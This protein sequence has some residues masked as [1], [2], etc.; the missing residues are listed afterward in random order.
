MKISE[1]VEKTYYR[2]LSKQHDPAH[3]GHIEWYTDDEEHAKLYT[4]GE[5]DATIITNDI[6]DDI[7][8]HSFEHGFR[9]EQTEITAED[10]ADRVK[11]GIVSAFKQGWIDKESAIALTDE[12]YDIEFPSVY[13]KV[14]MWWQ[15]WHDFTDILKKAGYKAI[16]NIENN[17][18]TYGIIK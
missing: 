17:I 3:A 18:D 7:I 8:T 13:K 15:E 10:F 16:H 6:P 2:G 14:F 1:L 9:S 12:L 4:D 5:K 11:N